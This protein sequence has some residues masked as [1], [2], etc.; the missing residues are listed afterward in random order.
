[1]QE[2]ACADMHICVK[3]IRYCLLPN[4]QRPLTRALMFFSCFQL[5]L[6]AIKCSFCQTNAYKCLMRTL[7]YIVS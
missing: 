2:F 5:Q 1:M 6:N 4:A 7:H 3:A